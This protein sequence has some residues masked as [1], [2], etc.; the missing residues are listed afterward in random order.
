MRQGRSSGTPGIQGLVKGKR[1]SIQP[2]VSGQNPHEPQQ[3]MPAHELFF[4][5]SSEHAAARLLCSIAKD[6]L[7]ALLLT[8]FLF[9]GLR[10]FLG[11]DLLDALLLLKKVKH[12]LP[13]PPSVRPWSLLP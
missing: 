3:V 10:Q 13:Q 5:K 2:L 6:L 11:K 4:L 12:R 9:L 1:S 7:L 8:S